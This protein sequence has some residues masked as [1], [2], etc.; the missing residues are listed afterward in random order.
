MFKVSAIHIEADLERVMEWMSANVSAARCPL[1]YKQHADEQLIIHSTRIYYTIWAANILSVII[2]KDMQILLLV[3]S[4]QCF[5]LHWM[6]R[7]TFFHIFVTSYW[8]VQFVGHFY[9]LPKRNLVV[10]SLRTIY[11]TS[12]VMY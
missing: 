1:K 10:Q 4:I 9:T 8:Q 3:C 12:C 11:C 7:H 5:S 2:C 6:W